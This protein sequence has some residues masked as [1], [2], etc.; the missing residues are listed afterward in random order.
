MRQNYGRMS[1]P[2][3]LAAYNT[4]IGEVTAYMAVVG[5][6]AG[7]ALAS[8]KPVGKFSD[9]QTGIKR[10]QALDSA[11]AKATKA[12]PEM[13]AK[14]EAAKVREPATKI[15][16]TKPVTEGTPATDAPKKSKA[17]KPATDAP[18]EKKTR[19]PAAGSEIRPGSNRDLLFQRLHSSLG[20]PVHE[21]DLMIAVYGKATPE[22]R[23]PLNMIIKGFREVQLE[24]LKMPFT[25]ERSKNGKDVTYRLAGK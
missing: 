25:L 24:G 23:G 13:Q 14:I 16:K 1:G 10:C 15:E 12:D 22:L 8:F 7:K 6:E 18:K 5:T 4:M 21:N 9:R 3:L 19:V 17:T 11:L 2:E 20:K